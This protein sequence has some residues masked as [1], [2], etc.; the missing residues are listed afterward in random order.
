MSRIKVITLTPEQQ[1]A[2]EHGYRTG[3]S[4][5]FRQRCQIILLKSQSRTSQDVARIVGC[6]EMVVNNWMA[7][8]QREGID[9]L[10]TK[11][12]RG[13]K[14]ILD[15]QTDLEQVREAVRGDRQRLRVA[16]ADLEEALGKSFS[17]KTLRRFLKDTLH[18]INASENAP[19]GSRIRTSIS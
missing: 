9:G 10:H 13:R 16:K 7:R 14:A 3:Q 18:A 15:A 5:A 4:A 19:A 8:Y 17:D 2:L 11:P 12:G 1:T 6:C